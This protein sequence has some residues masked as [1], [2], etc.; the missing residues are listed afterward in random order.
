MNLDEVRTKLLALR[1][2][3]TARHERIDKHIH[4]RDEP[5]AQDSEERAGESSNDETMELLDAN[6]L[7]EL[8]QIDHALARIDLGTYGQCEK[9]KDPIPEERLEFLPYTSQCVSCTVD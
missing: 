8:Q 2:E 7:E 4:H 1:K 5:R 9:C 6:A 3:L